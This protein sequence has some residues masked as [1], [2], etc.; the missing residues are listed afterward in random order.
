[1]TKTILEENFIFRP[2][3]E[4]LKSILHNQEVTY[5]RKGFGN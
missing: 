4:D 1:M 2:T 3:N 5:R